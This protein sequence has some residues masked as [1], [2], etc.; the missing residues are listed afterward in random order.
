MCI[1]TCSF[2][3][4]GGGLGRKEGK[5]FIHCFD[6]PTELKHY[7]VFRFGVCVLMIPQN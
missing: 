4:G 6:D 3:L 1:C 2:S 7:C 5:P